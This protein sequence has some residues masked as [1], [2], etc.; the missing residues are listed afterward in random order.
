MNAELYTNLNAAL[1]ELFGEGTTVTKRTGVSGGDINSAYL[2]ELSNGA[3][4]FMKENSRQNLGFFTA[5]AEGLRA[6]RE[7]CT[8]TAAGISAE[9]GT[10]AAAGT[11][12]AEYLQETHA[13]RV[14]EAP[15]VGCGERHSFLLMEPIEEGRRTAAASEAL[16]R[17]LARMHLADAQKFAGGGRFGFLHDNFIGAGSQINTPKSSWIEFFSECR[18][19]PQF[20]RAA[21]WFSKEERAAFDAFLGRLDRYLAEP[22]QPSLL[23]GDLWAGNYMIDQKETP[24]LIDPAAYVGHAEADLAMTE[25]FGGFDR[26]FYDAYRETAGIDPGYPERRNLYNLYHL[27]NHLNLFGGTYLY[28]VRSILKAYLPGH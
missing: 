5:E 16:G 17:G 26:R 15:A 27:L 6:L 18:L 7:A 2:L 9:A 12:T 28:S 10:S 3:R 24:W 13:L 22:A 19:R 11:S 21:S 23:H 4:L 20:E 14:P 25:L 8:A 1:E